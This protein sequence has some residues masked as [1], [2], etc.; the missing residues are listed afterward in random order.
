MSRRHAELGHPLMFDET[1]GLCGNQLFWWRSRSGYQV[2]MTC[3][4]DPLAALEILARRG[5]PG[6]VQ[7]VQA[8]TRASS[9]L[10]DL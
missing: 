1:C 7:H 10:V 8:W 2:C 5:K 9:Y 4:P 3:H 6:L